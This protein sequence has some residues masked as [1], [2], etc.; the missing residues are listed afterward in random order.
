L[1]LHGCRL[2]ESKVFFCFH[3]QKWLQPCKHFTTKLLL[4]PGSTF[5]LAHWTDTQGRSCVCSGAPWV[6]ARLLPNSPLYPSPCFSWSLM[7]QACSYLRVLAL[8][9]PST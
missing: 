2:E 4:P 9:V 6:S 8:S 1:R 7:Y 5:L 3:K